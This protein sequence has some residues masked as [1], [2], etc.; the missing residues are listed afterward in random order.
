M[1][2]HLTHRL[3][4]LLSIVLLGTWLP[5]ASVV[6]TSPA[7][8]VLVAAASGTVPADALQPPPP[9]TQRTLQ[10]VSHPPL[11]GLALDVAVAPEL[12]AVGETA[13]ISLTVANRSPHPAAELVI[14]LPTPEGALA[15]PGPGTLGPT[16]GWR[17][18]LGQLVGEQH[19]ILTATLRLVRMPPGAA[20]LVHPSARA[21]GVTWPVHAVGGALVIDRA[22]G[23]ATVSFS[24]GTPAVLRSNDGSVTVQIPAR[25]ATQPLTL[26]HTLIPLPGA[27]APAARAGFKRSFPPFFLDAIGTQGVAVHRFTDPLTLTV[28]YTPEQLQALGINEA[29][30]TLFHFDAAQQRWLP[31]PTMIDSAARTASARVDHFSAWALS[32]GSSP[33][34]AYLPSLQGFQVSTF[35]GAASYRIPLELPAGPGGLKPA[36]ALSYS[37]AASDGSTGDRPF[38]QAGLVGKGWTLDAGGA[39]ARHTSLAGP[40][41]DHFTL[42]FSGQAFDLVRGQ[43]TNGCT[44]YA[45]TASLQ[46]W[47]WHAVDE[48]FVR[49]RAEWTGAGHIWKAWTKDGIR[50]EF[51]QPLRNRPDPDL[52]AT[53][54]YQWLLTAVVDPHGNRIDYLYQVDTVAGTDLNP[55][56]YLR[57]IRW[58]YDGATPGT[59]TPRYK[60]TFTVASRWASPTEGVD[61]QWEY[62]YPGNSYWQQV[63]PHEAY[64]L[65][66]ISVWSRPGASDELV[67]RLVLSYYPTSASATTDS[68]GGQPVLT[69]KQVQLVGSDGAA[70]L[71]PTTFTYRPRGTAQTPA[72]G[73]NRLWEVD[74]GQGGKLTF[75]Y[76]NVWVAGAITGE[77]AYL[78]ENYHRVTSVLRQDVSGQRYSRSALTTYEYGPAARNEYGSA[79]TVVYA[80]YP[81]S[82]N[83][84]SRQFLARPEKREFRGHAWVTERTYDVVTTTAVLLQQITHWFYQG[85]AGCT[86]MIVD[87][88]VV[89]TDSCFQ[90]M[91]RREAWKGKEYQTEVRNADGTLLQRTIHSFAREELPFFGSDA[92]MAS[93]SNHYRRAGLWRAFNYERQTQAQL[94]EG[95]TTPRTKT[96]LYF[97]DPVY[98]QGGGRYGNLGKIEEYSETGALVRRTQRW[99]NTRDDGVSYLVDR[100]WGEVVHDANGVAQQVTHWFYYDDA[101]Q[102]AARPDT[103]GLGRRGLLWRMSRYRNATP[104][105]TYPLEASDVTYTYDAY[106]NRTGTTTYAG[107]GQMTTG[108]SWTAPGNGSTARTTTTTYDGTFHVFPVQVVNALGHREQAGYDYRMGTLTSVTD[109]NGNTTSAQYDAFGR[110]AMLVKPGDNASSPTARFYYYDWEQ[111]FR[112]LIQQWSGGSGD[113]VRETS[114]F[115]DGLGQLVQTKVESGAWGTQ[116]IVTDY[117]VDGLDRRIAQSQPRYVNETSSTFWTYTDPGP[118]LY[119]PTTTTYDALGRPL[120]LTQPDGTWSE[121]HYGVVVVNNAAWGYDDVVDPNRHRIQRRYDALGRLRQVIEIQGD[122]GNWGYTCAAPSTTPWQVDT[123]TSYDYT[124]LDLL[125]RVTDAY[126]NVTSMEYDSLGRKIQMTDPD[127]G[128]WSYSYDPNG[129]LQTQTDAKGQTL[130]FGYDALDRLREKRL[131]GAA[132]T[133]LAAYAYDEAVPNGLGRRTAMATYANGTTQT[134]V[135]WEYDARGRVALAG[136]HVQGISTQ[137]RYSY[138]S[139]DR[140]QTLRYEETGEVVSYTYDAAW[141]PQS[142]CTNLGGCYVN[143][144]TYTALD[145]PD[146]W[147]LGND[148]VQDWSYTSPMQRLERLQLGGLFDRGY[149]YDAGGNITTLRDYL[150]NQTQHFSYDHRD[151]LIHAWTS[152]GLAT[153]SNKLAAAL[154]VDRL[155]VSARE[156]LQ[157]LAPPD[158]DAWPHHAASGAPAPALQDATRIK[159]STFEAGSLT[160]PLS[161]V[162]ST[163]GPVALETA[164]PLRGSYAARIAPTGAPAYLVEEFSAATDLYVAFSLRLNALPTDDVR[165][166]QIQSAGTTIGALVLRPSG[167][168]QLRNGTTNLGTSTA[169]LQPGTLYRIGL[170]QKQGSGTDAVLEAYLVEGMAPFGAPFATLTSGTW[171]TPADRVRVGATTAVPLDAVVD[172]LVLDRAALP[173]PPDS[174]P[175][176]TPTSPPPPTA[177]PAPGARL[178]DMT[179]EGGSLTDPATGADRL[180]GAVLPTLETVA[181]IKGAYAAHTA[182]TGS[183]YLRADFPP[184]TDLYVALYIRLNALPAADVRLVQILAAGTAI[185]DLVLNEHGQLRLRAFTNTIG[186]PVGPLQVGVVYRLG[187][188]QRA[189][190]GADA[191][192]EGYLATGDAPFGAPFAR[193]SQGTWTTPADRLKVGGTNNPVDL[194]L[195]DVALD[196]AA[197]PPPSAGTPV[198]TPTSPMAPTATPTATPTAVPTATPLPPPPGYD[199]W[200][201][202]D[203]LGNLTSKAGVSYRYGANG[204]GT[205]AGP[206]Q[207]RTVGG[208]PYTYDANGN[209]LSGGGRTYSW[210][211]EN[212]PTSSTSGGVAE[213]YTYDADGERVA[214]TVQGVTTVMFAGLWERDSTGGTRTF[215]MFHGQVVAMRQGRAVT[216]LHGDH[217]GSISVATGAGGTL[218]S[219][220]AFDPWGAVRSGGISQT[221]L[222]YTGQRLDGTGLLYYHARYYDPVLGRFISA[223]SVVPGA[224]ALTVWPGDGTARAAWAAGGGGPANPQ[225]LN[226]YSYGLNNPVKNTDPT[227]HWIESAIDIAFIAYDLYDISQN[228]LTWTSGLALA[229]DVASLALPAVAGGGAAVRALAHADEVVD[230]VR[231]VDTADD[232]TRLYR[233][234]RAGNDGLPITGPSARTLG[235]RPEVDIP[236]DAH[237]SVQPGSGGMSVSPD[238]PMNLPSHRRPANMGG[239]GKDPV[240][241]IRACDLGPDLTYRP[242]PKHPSGHGF[243]EPARPM[244]FVDYQRALEGTRG[245]WRCI[246]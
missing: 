34:S 98:Q 76:A 168:L 71:P 211:A 18:D 3:S 26:R 145:Q 29:D 113:I 68:L 143:N 199:A 55:T 246:E 51:T 158:A 218:L 214:R 191:V 41:W 190:S 90:E 89:E 236:V 28:R 153:G 204:N 163:T 30:L 5:G 213:S 146:Q 14:T 122:C 239:T 11:P 73:A 108:T 69:L 109:A 67:R 187:I 173:L 100:V 37:S 137:L 56:W 128:T 132:G 179:F 176:L 232:G 13:T 54:V 243:V 140:I 111:P 10:P 12:V 184:T 93:A 118:I 167:A 185:G 164:A 27:S 21:R 144:A 121:H 182:G 8:P 160:D 102:G 63:T 114:H 196:A 7:A 221:S 207:A 174:A 206:H 142:L 60:V 180:E 72:A 177:T 188:H 2:Q 147:T 139:A 156:R 245:S 74:N 161:G 94:F 43:L 46:C 205:G 59:G 31:V 231:A 58:G 223:D 136:Q 169:P 175:T 65:D 235:V 88:K 125:A 95:T 238:S 208:Q 19:T 80:A 149:S 162:D 115:Y 130:W 148:L 220:Q 152:A 62:P 172:D 22:R 110:L 85:N 35:T 17:W 189:G 124:A 101:G 227:G 64:R 32:D 242:D 241:C 38:W 4:L 171:T 233:S 77:P 234:M 82:G 107:Y 66:Q 228:G 240:W 33:S 42:V 61:T 78:H 50:Y 200:Y 25:A 202:Y 103:N 135:R 150:A 210:D 81:P 53:Q 97:Y 24:P 48:N 224:G 84:E 87:Q 226:R 141:R 215:Y 116:N 1:A 151:R 138:D 20:L 96:T 165:I 186:A 225:D 237:G 49:V 166:A 209:L 201:Q 216:Y 170:R 198:P 134:S 117:R 244:S 99:Y 222:N 105:C 217:L 57:E 129:N 127:M 70:V 106:G 154:P 23:A 112:Y 36:V 40:M 79:A 192:L 181:P 159:E 44:N 212:R 39:V 230:A 194:V 229:A 178:K 203:A 119:R 45:D 9:P 195:D 123:T 197:L 6:A 120:R 131:G 83:G 15:L 133:L 155:P 157:P 47:T 86:P 193:T 92:A 183:S 219:Q 75:S 91:V 52:S 16:Q 126:G 104:C